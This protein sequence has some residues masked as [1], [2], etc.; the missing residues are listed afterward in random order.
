MKNLIGPLMILGLLGALSGCT[1]M[2][3][4]STTSVPVERGKKV[5]AK[6]ENFIVLGLNFDNDYVN[7]LTQDLAQQ[8]PEGRVEGILT[9]MEEITY[10]P[11][12]AHAVEITATGYC[13]PRGASAARG[14]AA[15]PRAQEAPKPAE[16]EGGTL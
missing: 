10:F 3:S 16:A 5:S 12:F 13:V 11:L 7:G 1:H 6:A 8:C 14:E 4:I 15:P 9:K 2:A